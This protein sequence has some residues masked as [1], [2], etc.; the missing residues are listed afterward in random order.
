MKI[1]LTEEQYKKLRLEQMTTDSLNV[2]TQVFDL[3]LDTKS[4]ENYVFTSKCCA[5]HY[6]NL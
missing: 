2:V 6:N 5:T 3:D 4:Y 1:K